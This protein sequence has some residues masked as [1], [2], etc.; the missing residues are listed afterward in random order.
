MAKTLEELIEECVAM[1]QSDK[2]TKEFSLDREEDGTWSAAI[3][4]HAHVALGEWQGEF[5]VTDKPT[6]KDAVLALM[7]RVREG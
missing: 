3:G 6:A 2:W 7:K 4:G 5:Y 1:Y